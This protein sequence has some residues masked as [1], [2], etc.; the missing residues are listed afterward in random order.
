MPSLLRY[1]VVVLLLSL[2]VQGNI[3]AMKILSSE[4]AIL[5]EITAFLPGFIV[6]PWGITTTFDFLY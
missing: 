4:I 6:S 1:Q 3:Q 2:L 5:T